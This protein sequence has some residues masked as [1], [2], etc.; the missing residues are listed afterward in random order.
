[1]VDSASGSKISFENGLYDFSVESKRLVVEK[2]LK[3]LQ[4]EGNLSEAELKFLSYSK[5]K[6]SSAKLLEDIVST[7]L[8]LSN[9]KEVFYLQN[10]KSS[11][12]TINPD[13]KVRNI[14]YRDE[15]DVIVATLQI[16]TLSKKMRLQNLGN[17]LPRLECFSPSEV[18][19]KI[20]NLARFNNWETEDGGINLFNGNREIRYKDKNGNV[21]AAIIT[22]EN[23]AFDT[24]AE[25]EYKT[26]Y[27]TKMTLTNTFGNSIVMYDGTKQVNQT[28]RI[29]IDN[30]GMIIEI[31][32]VYTD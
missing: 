14:R 5:E 16:D 25:Y 26:G 17:F 7:N 31:T 21:M 15:A 2:F 12:G 9:Y 8:T 4:S 27:R 6:Q 20:Q 10:Y 28:V 24:I 3:N 32:K 1:M 18:G 11:V 29:D 23:G 13:Q 30:D 19:T 22:K